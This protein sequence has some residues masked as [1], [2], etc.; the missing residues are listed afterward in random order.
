MTDAYLNKNAYLTTPAGPA[1]TLP[2]TMPF[3]TLLSMLTRYVFLGQD[4]PA[5]C[6]DIEMYDLLLKMPVPDWADSIQTL[7]AHLM[8]GFLLMADA[9]SHQH[10]SVLGGWRHPNRYTKDDLEQFL[11]KESTLVQ[12]KSI[13]LY[14]TLEEDVRQAYRLARSAQVDYQQERRE[15]WRGKHKALAKCL[16]RVHQQGIQL[17]EIGGRWFA[18]VCLR[19][20]FREL[21]EDQFGPKVA[22]PE[23]LQ[24]Y[25]EEVKLT[26]DQRG[27]VLRALLPE[28]EAGWE[29]PEPFGEMVTAYELGEW[30][31]SLSPTVT[32]AEWEA[33]VPERWL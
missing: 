21:W 27:A 8:E 23:A 32:E 30:P 14:S 7:L 24:P 10:K 12:A 15:A 22:Y 16:L 9:R 3:R 26:L 25:I 19:R 17:C 33:R 20:L 18:E 31:Q 2:M 29:V 13:E 5:P 6:E 1:T 11:Y 28:R 4:A